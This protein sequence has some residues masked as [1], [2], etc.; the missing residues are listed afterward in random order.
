MLVA[1]HHELGRG[2]ATVCDRL[3]EVAV[4]KLQLLL[5]QRVDIG[6]EERDLCSGLVGGVHRCDDAQLAFDQNLL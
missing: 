2:Q 5:R 3:G 4:A 1:V 6:W